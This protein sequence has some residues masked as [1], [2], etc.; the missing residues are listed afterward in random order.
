VPIL[1]QGQLRTQLKAGEVG[2]LYVLVGSD[3]AEKASVAA[4]FGELVDEGLRAFNYERLYGGE[5]SV[6]DLLQAANTLPMMSPRR[7]V[8]VLEAEKLLVPKRESKA[9]DEDQKRLEVLILDPSP[10]A[11]VVFVCGLLDRRR[12]AVKLLIDRASVVDCGT[13]EDAADAER[14]VKTRAAKEGVNLDPGA[15][16]VLVDRGG[17]DLVRLRS[18]LERVMLYALGQP[19]ITADDVKQVVSPAPDA[20][21]EF[22][23]ANAVQNGNAAAA[24]RQLSAA[25]EAGA[26]PFFLMGQLRWVAEK[27]PAARMRE[28]IEA[29]FRTDL[30][31]KSSG[32]DPR[33][34]L[35]RLVVELS[36]MAATGGRRPGYR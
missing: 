27:A 35:E 15:V 23:I 16:R 11:T 8:V 33:I 29:V 9:G 20:Q 13:I 12:R 2:P 24:L 6:D 14:W 3:D 32:G 7:I 10:H 19:A 28:A 31:L 34:L 30:A 1:T 21:E 26:V 17:N 18:A 22:G 36:G 25:L 5:M 4:E